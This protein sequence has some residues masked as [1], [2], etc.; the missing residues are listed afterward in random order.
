VSN[1]EAT[2]THNALV[3]YPETGKLGWYSHKFIYYYCQNHDY[4]FEAARDPELLIKRARETAHPVHFLHME[5]LNQELFEFLLVKGY[6]LRRIEFIQKKAKINTSRKNHD[7]R[8]WYSEQ[9]RREI[10]EK[11]ALVF[12]LFP[13]FQF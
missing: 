2:W 3:K 5:R 7:Y 12:R 8:E 9:L 1:R 4:V 11:D 6:P 13:E 10:E